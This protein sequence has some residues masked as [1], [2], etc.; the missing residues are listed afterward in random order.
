MRPG[1]DKLSVP[2]WEPALLSGD[3]AMERRW[4]VPGRET[5]SSHP[6]REDTVNPGAPRPKCTA[7]LEGFMKL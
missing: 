1:P 5:A 3:L 2:C 4:G 6:G 7:W